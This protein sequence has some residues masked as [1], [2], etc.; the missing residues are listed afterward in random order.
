MRKI[1]SKVSLLFISTIILVVSGCVSAP[2]KDIQ[3]DMVKYLNNKY[4]Q[5]FVV[6]KP[7]AVN[8]SYD[9]LGRIAC[10][11]S[12]AYL[13]NQ[14]SIR[15]FFSFPNS[16]DNSIKG[17]YFEYDVYLEKK[18]SYEA[19]SD[20]NK[21][22]N[23]EYSNSKLIYYNIRCGLPKSNSNDFIEKSDYNRTYSDVLS[24]YNKN[25]NVS[26]KYIVFVDSDIDKAAEAKKVYSIFEKTIQIYNIQQ[27]YIFIYYVP[28]MYKEDALKKCDDIDFDNYK[29]IINK[30]EAHNYFSDSAS[31]ISSDY[32]LNNFK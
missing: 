11:D 8:K 3:S 2:K 6:E 9:I 17:E 4:S 18:W 25:L 19:L 23:I 22:L 12:Y 28:I 10:Y 1:C 13:K 26:Y 30:V 29:Y 32:F 24:K 5:E 31:D 14:P 7:T 27:F 21:I 20:V 16:F 15:F